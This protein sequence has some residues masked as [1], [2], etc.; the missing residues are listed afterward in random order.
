M[1]PYGQ[2]QMI[3]PNLDKL[4]AGGLTFNGAYAQ[5]AVCGPSRASFMSECL[6]TVLADHPT[7]KSS[8]ATNF[9]HPRYLRSTGAYAAHIPIGA[10]MNLDES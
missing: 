2:K 1:G 6:F 7:N 4:A 5:Q 3:T 10:A 9:K 8:R